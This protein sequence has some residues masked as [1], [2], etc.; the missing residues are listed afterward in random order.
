[1]I[2]VERFFQSVD[3]QL[4]TLFGVAVADQPASNGHYFVASAGG[5]D[6]DGWA[7]RA[8]TPVHSRN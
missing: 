7:I 5:L 1:V 6:A 8:S 2:G 4:V 3:D